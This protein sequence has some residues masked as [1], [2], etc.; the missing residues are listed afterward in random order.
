[1][2]RGALQP[3]GSTRDVDASPADDAVKMMSAGRGLHLLLPR[4]TP[5][6]C[7]DGPAGIYDHR[8]LAAE[9]EENA[10][11]ARKV[12]GPSR[13]HRGHDRDHHGCRHRRR[14]SL[15]H[16]R[17]SG[18]LRLKNLGYKD[19][20]SPAAPRAASV[21]WPTPRRPTRPVAP[22]ARP[23]PPAGRR[24]MRRV[25]HLDHASLAD[26]AS[27]APRTS[28]RRT[29]VAPTTPAS[30]PRLSLTTVLGTDAEFKD[31]AV[32]RPQLLRDDHRRRRPV[33][34]RPRQCVKGV[35]S[36]YEVYVITGCKKPF[37]RCDLDRFG[38]RRPHLTKA[39]RRARTHLENLPHPAR[40]RVQDT[41]D[42]HTTSAPTADATGHA[43]WSRSTYR[44]GSVA[45]ARGAG[46]PRVDSAGL[47]QG[48]SRRR[49]R[50][51]R[52]RPG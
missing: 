36:E 13:R 46:Q 52:T 5:R 19:D 51:R 9:D 2:H 37:R 41:V 27:T 29:P 7:V 38:R 23:R 20:L 18:Q 12:A 21:Y 4:R 22:A 40:H 44:L 6:G 32:P 3:P 16:R 45:T 43:H 35:R 24:I 15:R 28:T 48:T 14:R 10:L 49:P 31:R 8:D 39:D 34:R 33:D 30:A 47:R 17:R 11:A 42:G 50:P 25:L 1:M 26:L